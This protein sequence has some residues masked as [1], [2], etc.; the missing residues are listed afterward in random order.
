MVRSGLA[1]PHAASKREVADL[2]AIVDRNLADAGVEALSTDRRFAIAYEAALQLAKIAVACTGWRI[3]GAGHHQ[4]TFVGLE[5]AVGSASAPLA[6]YFEVCRRKRN[7]LE[8]D[9]AMIATDT[10]VAEIIAK[11]LELRTLVSGWLRANYP[12]LV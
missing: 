1:R 11:A 4:N 8:Y 12:G 7:R 5:L 6:A 10:E 2:G 3:V 9:S